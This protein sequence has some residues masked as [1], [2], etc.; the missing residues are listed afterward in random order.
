MTWVRDGWA[1]Y[2]ESDVCDYTPAQKEHAK[3]MEKWKNK[4]RAAWRIFLLKNKAHQ[5]KENYTGIV[6]RSRKHQSY[7]DDFRRELREGPTPTYRWDYQQ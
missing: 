1:K 7:E 6:D 5:D 4:R 3:N 2:E